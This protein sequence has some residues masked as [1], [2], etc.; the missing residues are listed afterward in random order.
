MFLIG[1][2]VEARDSDSG[3]ATGSDVAGAYCVV[4]EAAVE[5]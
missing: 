3:T 1:D 4:V 5:F 2:G